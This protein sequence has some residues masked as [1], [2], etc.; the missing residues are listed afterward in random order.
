VGD[1]YSTFSGTLIYGDPITGLCNTTGAAC[2]A[3]P[4]IAPRYCI[5]FRNTV[6]AFLLSEFCSRDVMIV[7]M[8]YTRGGGKRELTVMSADF[9]YDSEELPHERG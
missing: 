3:G 6:H 2:S 5:F 4:D 1:R 7:R 9:P 8:T